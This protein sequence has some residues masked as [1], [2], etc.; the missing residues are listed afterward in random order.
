M[1]AG[2]DHDHERRSGIH[3]LL[4]LEKPREV[5]EERAHEIAS[6]LG[7]TAAPRDTMDAFTF[8]SEYLAYVQETR[9]AP[10]PAGRTP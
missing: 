7:Y 2:A 10:K 3:R 6:R 8:N 1:P 4:P 9:E 5:L